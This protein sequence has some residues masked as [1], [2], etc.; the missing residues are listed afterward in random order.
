[1]NID[2]R[3]PYYVLVSEKSERLVELVESRAEL[4]LAYV[5]SD[6]WT[7]SLVCVRE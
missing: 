3:R 2:G 1:M 6:G 4:E 5:R 7:Q